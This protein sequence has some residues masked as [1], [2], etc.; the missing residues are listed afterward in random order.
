MSLAVFALIAWGAQAVVHDLAGNVHR[1]FGI[2]AICAGIVSG[3]SY[4]T[5]FRPGLMA[6]AAWQTDPKR[7]RFAFVVR[8][9]WVLPLVGALVT[10]FAV[11]IG[12]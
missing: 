10:G 4:V 2:A 3:R 7:R 5:Y 11:T 8:H 6:D 12:T 1:W 9:V